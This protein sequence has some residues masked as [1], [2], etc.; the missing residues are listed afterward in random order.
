MWTNFTLFIIET[1]SIENKKVTN[2]DCIG[3]KNTDV[4]EWVQKIHWL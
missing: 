4:K 1:N 2:S 3:E